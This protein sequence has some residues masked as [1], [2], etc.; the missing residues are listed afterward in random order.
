MSRALSES[1][2]MYLIAMGHVT[3]QMPYT[4]TTAIASNIIISNSGIAAP[5]LIVRLFA[6]MT[7]IACAVLVDRVHC[8]A[9]GS[10]FKE[11]TGWIMS[12]HRKSK[13]TAECHSIIGRPIWT[14]N[15]PYIDCNTSRV[16]W[17]WPLTCITADG[18]LKTETDWYL[19]R[20]I[21]F[22]LDWWSSWSWKLS[23][24]V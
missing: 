16:R 4:T 6:L 11:P 14:S 5:L 10:L 19:Q 7:A 18:R 8:R 21:S 3:M 2:P 23:A 9:F 15:V 12:P 20:F 17:I 1:L 13:S 22:D 24:V